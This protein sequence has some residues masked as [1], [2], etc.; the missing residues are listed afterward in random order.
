[1]VCAP[2]VLV[3]NTALQHKMPRFLEILIRG[4]ASVGAV[5]GSDMDETGC[6]YR[7]CFD[8]YLRLHK[9]QG[10]NHWFRIRQ[11]LSSHCYFQRHVLLNQRRFVRLLSHCCD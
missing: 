11:R 5:F 1:M 4:S 6:K 2:C 10:N 7:Y 9:L 8:T 3:A